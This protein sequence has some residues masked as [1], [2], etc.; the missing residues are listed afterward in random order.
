MKWQSWLPT[1]TATRVV[2]EEGLARTFAHHLAGAEL[3]EVDRGLGLDE[4]DAEHGASPLS[5]SVQLLWVV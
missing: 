2:V 5:C 1:G 3:H 4:T